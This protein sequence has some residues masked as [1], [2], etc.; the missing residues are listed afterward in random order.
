MNKKEIVVK[1][2]TDAKSLEEVLAA[3]SHMEFMTPAKDPAERKRYAEKL[4]AT[5]HAIAE[6]HD[7]KPMGM[8]CF[9][10]NDVETRIGYITLFALMEE[11]GF[12]KGRTMFNLAKLSAEIA[13]R[14]GMDWVRIEVDDR[15]VLARKLYERMGFEYTE[16]KEHSSIMLVSLEKLLGN[17]KKLSGESSK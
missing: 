17:F 3:F 16:K 7:G 8:M 12:A 5:G 10:C 6:F 9:Y 1:E 11:L 15:N 2:I 13:D 4:L 14:T